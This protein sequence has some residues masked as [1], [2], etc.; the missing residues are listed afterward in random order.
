MKTKKKASKDLLTLIKSLIE[1]HDNGAYIT[2][3][4]I[5]N[6]IKETDP[7]EGYK[8]FAPTGE[9]HIS[10]TMQHKQ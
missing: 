10:I 8:S 4:D 6:D 5:T 3:L 9:S 1:L 2:R 7:K